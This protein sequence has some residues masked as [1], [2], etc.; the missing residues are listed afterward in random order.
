MLFHSFCRCT[1]DQS[2]DN[3][4]D[5]PSHG[6]DD[7]KRPRPARIRPDEPDEY[8]LVLEKRLAILGDTL[9]ELRME[10]RR[11]GGMRS[12]S[13][14]PSGLSQWLKRFFKWLTS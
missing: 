6:H 3:L 10:N 11:L 13:L 5:T 8:T 9:E 7:D 14:K 12:K 2:G 1:T 4:S